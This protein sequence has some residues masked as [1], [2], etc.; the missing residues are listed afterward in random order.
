MHIYCTCAY[1]QIII[2]TICKLRRPCQVKHNLGSK[3]LTHTLTAEKI[4]R[5]GHLACDSVISA[6]TVE[7][8]AHATR[9]KS[10]APATFF[11]ETNLNSTETKLQIR[12]SPFLPS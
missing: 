3:F 6:R 4:D 8:P 11:E 7:I 12:P 10:L 9:Q 2:T 5:T 1:K